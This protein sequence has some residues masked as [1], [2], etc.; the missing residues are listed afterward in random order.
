M[1][2]QTFVN[3]HAETRKPWTVAASLT[4]QAGCV[5]TVLLLPLLH[6]GTITPRF[7]FQTPLILTKLAPPP[8]RPELPRTAAAA[9]RLRGIF[10]SP[11]LPPRTVPMRI[12]MTPD[13]APEIVSLPFAIAA[14][15]LDAL[16][17]ARPFAPTPPPIPVARTSQPPA[18][19]LRVSGTV[20][21]ALLIFGPKPAYPP[22]AKATRVQG[23][24]RLEATIG[25][26]GAIRNLRMTSGPALL[27][28]AAL[29][30][31]A[32]WRYRPTLL[33]GE[34][35]EV[36]TQIDVNFTLN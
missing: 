25:P 12:D 2:E 31:V 16:P 5:V 23:T 8:L 24:V 26:D 3:A 33:N 15:V 17:A 18:T 9:P 7:D 29:E 11:L 27:A 30:A 36:M 10:S 13:P 1:F 28:G 14:S 34:P 20:Q 19:L 6:P 4:L 22:L 21:S 35:V 32:R